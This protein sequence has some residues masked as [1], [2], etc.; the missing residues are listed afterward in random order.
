METR[1]LQSGYLSKCKVLF[2]VEEASVVGL[3]LD[4]QKVFWGLLDVNKQRIIKQATKE[5]KTTKNKT[6]SNFSG[7]NRANAVRGLNG[8]RLYLESIL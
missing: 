6:R 1:L 2:D 8:L 3:Q 4:L 5:K 7:T